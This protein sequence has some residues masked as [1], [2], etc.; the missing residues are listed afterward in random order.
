MLM[1]T[2]NFS[3]WVPFRMHLLLATFFGSRLWSDR[4]R[5]LEKGNREGGIEREIWNLKGKKAIKDL[6]CLKKQAASV[7]YS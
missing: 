7:Y 3:P 5:H 6:L 1:K 4:R 2:T